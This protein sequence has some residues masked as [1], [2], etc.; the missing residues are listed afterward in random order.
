MFTGHSLSTQI[1]QVYCGEN[2]LPLG[3]GLT[4]NLMTIRQTQPG[5]PERHT[6]K[7][8]FRLGDEGM[9]RLLILSAGTDFQ[10]TLSPGKI[11]RFLPN[12]ARNLCMKYSLKQLLKIEIEQMSLKKLESSFSCNVSL[13]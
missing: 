2:N 11:T 5:E 1:V 4:W 6:R 3:P 12:M 9:S 13:M 8:M 10:L 7:V